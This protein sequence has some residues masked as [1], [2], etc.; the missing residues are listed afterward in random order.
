MYVSDELKLKA[1]KAILLE[2]IQKE[3]VIKA[4]YKGKHDAFIEASIIAKLKGEKK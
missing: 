2:K 1:E 3:D 4:Y